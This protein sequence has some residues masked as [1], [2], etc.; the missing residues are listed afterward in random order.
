MFWWFD[1]SFLLFFFLLDWLT[2]IFT[3]V[4]LCNFKVI[5]KTLTYKISLQC[6]VIFVPTSL[7][8]KWEL[9]KSDC[10]PS[11]PTCYFCLVVCFFFFFNS[12]FGKYYYFIWWVLHFCSPVFTEYPNISNFHSEIIV[13]LITSICLWKIT[14]T[15][16]L[17]CYL[18]TSKVYNSTPIFFWILAYES[19]ISVPF[20]CTFAG[21]SYGIRRAL[22]RRSVCFSWDALQYSSTWIFYLFTC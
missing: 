14:F 13:P 2:V 3:I 5:L 12:Q 15:V 7:W 6:K 16:S 19:V 22:S 9:F 11:H 20:V 21:C 18:N 10:H 4:L 1:A 8:T 17:H